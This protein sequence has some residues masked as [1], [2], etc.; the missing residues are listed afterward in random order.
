MDKKEE[1]DG[2]KA[3]KSEAASKLNWKEVLRFLQAKMRCEVSSS[4]FI[5]TTEAT[6][7]KKEKKAQK[8]Y[9]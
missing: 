3:T 5:F 2:E 4:P 6:S 1:E 8:K 9:L 7:Q